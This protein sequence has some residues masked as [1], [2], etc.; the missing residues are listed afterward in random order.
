MFTPQKKSGFTLVELLV[1]TAIMMMIF[2][3]VLANFRAGARSGE[4]DVALK[5]VIS[6]IG[7]VRNLTLGG[8]TVDNPTPPPDQIF[9][10]GGYGI[11]FD[12]NPTQFI[13]FNL[14]VADS[15]YESGDGVILTNGLKKFD[16]VDF[17]QFCG[18]NSIE[19]LP[20]QSPDWKDLKHGGDDYLEIIFPAPGEFFANYPDLGQDYDYVGGIIQHKKTFRRAYFLFSLTSGLL[21]GD[22]LQ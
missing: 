15:S 14:T 5:Q 7:L 16:D 12:K 10:L 18:S 8:Q 6:G 11:H 17:I 22:L 19:S 9:P 21:S 3:F 2:S 20:C 13:L 4:I 1:S